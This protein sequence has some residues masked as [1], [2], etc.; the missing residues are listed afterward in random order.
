L[1]RS[2]TFHERRMA[3]YISIFVNGASLIR[4]VAYKLR[5]ISKAPGAFP[6]LGMLRKEGCDVHPPSWFHLSLSQ[7]FTLTLA[8][9]P[10]VFY[11]SK[12]TPPMFLLE[13]GGYR[14]SRLVYSFSTCL[15]SL[16]CARAFSL[17]SNLAL[18]QFFFSCLLYRIKKTRSHLVSHILCA[19]TLSSSLRLRSVLGDS[20]STSARSCP[21]Q[22][23]WTQLDPRSFL[24]RKKKVNITKNRR[25]RC[26]SLPPSLVFLTFLFLL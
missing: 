14:H 4:F 26:L 3:V 7:S 25:Y 24:R 5:Y 19:T 1:E 9:L 17:S 13:N 2:A 20:S 23:A 12:R 15:L 18:P 21:P 10:A 22:Q 8:T 6:C 16:L 11:S